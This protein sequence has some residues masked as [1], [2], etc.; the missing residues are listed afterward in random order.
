MMKRYFL[1]LGMTLG[2]LG[3]NG[4]GTVDYY[5]LPDHSRVQSYERL[6]TR[7]GGA[8][9][10][11]RWYASLEG[12]VRTDRAKLDNSL[13][14]LVSSDRVTKFGTGAVIGWAYRERWAVEAGYAR[15][16]IHTQVSV[17]SMYSGPSYQYTNDRQGLVLRGKR[18]VLSTSGPWRRSGFW[19]STGLWLVPNSGRQEG[20]FALSG[21]VYKGRGES[22]DLF[23]LSGQTRINSR[24]TGLL[25]VGAEYSVRLTDN[26][27]LGLTARKYWGLGNSLTTNMIYSS[28]K[29]GTTQYAQLNGMGTGMAYGLTL[30]YTYSLRR[31]MPRVLD[32]RG[33]YK[34]SRLGR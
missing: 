15:M 34:S 3:A 5:R 17:N 18:Q 30:R 24:P 12:F 23:N 11:D 13:N 2:V 4:Q 26:L 31:T 20:Q 33:N 14:G 29:H 16:P 32:L 9:I 21:H 7:Y 1:F 25:E 22:P 10:Q 27:D 6:L 28:V 8:S 19:L